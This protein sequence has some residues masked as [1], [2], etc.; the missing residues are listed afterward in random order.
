MEYLA[1]ILTVLSRKP[2]RALDIMGA[3][4]SH[5]HEFNGVGPLRALSETMT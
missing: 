5:Q 2:S 4:K 1:R 3:N